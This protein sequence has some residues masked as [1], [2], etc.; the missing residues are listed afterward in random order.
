V[1]IGFMLVVDDYLQKKIFHHSLKH[2][3]KNR[4]YIEYYRTPKNLRK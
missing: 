4:E 3:V 2:Y 1:T